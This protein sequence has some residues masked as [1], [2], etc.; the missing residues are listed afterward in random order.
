MSIKS[1]DKIQII[2][3]RVHNLKNINVSILRNKLT[4][5]T[6][7]SGSGKSSLAFDT[8]YAEG[9][10]RYIESLSSY[11][12][13]FLGRIEKPDIDDIKGISPAIAIEQKVNSS[14]PR[15]TVGTTTEIHDYLKLLFA[16]I[17]KTISPLSNKQVTKDHPEDVLKWMLSITKKTKMLITCPIEPPKGRTL[18][19]HIQVYIQ[20]GYN[21]V[22][23]NNEI[24]ELEIKNTKLPFQLIIDRV[25]NENSNENQSR[26]LDSLELA[27]HEGKGN[28]EI[29]SF[30]DSQPNTNYF[31]NLFKKDDIVFEQPS[32]DFFSFNNPYGA[33]K[34]CEGFGKVMGIDPSLVIPNPNLSVYQDAIV[35]WK[36]EKMSVWKEELINNAHYFDFPIHEPFKDLS[37]KDQSTLWKGNDYFKGIDYFFK[38]LEKKSYKIQYRVLLSRYRGRTTCDDCNGNRLRA[39]ANYV[40]VNGVSI[41]EVNKMSIENAI[42]YFENI[43]LD[44]NDKLVAK[45]LIDEISSRLGYLCDVGLGYLTLNRPSNTLSGGESQRINLAT[46]IGSSLVGS[47]Y[48][49]DEPSIGLHS[50]DSQQ[51]IKV[52]KKLRDI[53]NSVIVVEH[54]EEMMRAADEIIDIG[55]YAGRHGGEVVFQGN[56]NKLINNKNSLTAKYLIGKM[57]I[58]VP[59]FRRKPKDFILIEEAFLHNLKNISVKI[60]LSQICVVTGVSGSGKSTLISNILHQYFERYFINGL[61]KPMHCSDIKVDFNLIDGVEFIDQNPIGKSSRSNPI[62][63]IKGYDDIRQ[64]FS[65]QKHAK[66]NG[67]KP[68]HFSFN[69]DGGRCEKCQGEGQLTITMQFMADVHLKCDECDGQRFKDEVLEVKF[70]NKNISEILDMTVEES[71]T[72]FDHED[73][74]CQKIKGKISALKEVG[75]EYVQL[76]QSSSTLSGGEA[77]RIKLAS[78]LTQNRTKNRKLFI[79]DEPTTGLHFHDVKKLIKALQDLIEMGHHIIII[80]HHLDIIKIADWIID[81]GLEG[82]DNGGD[83]IFQGNPEDFLKSNVISYTKNHLK[84]HIE[85]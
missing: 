41:S 77:Q 56:H 64:L 66:V 29:V 38:Y 9:H 16:R 57:K 62:T 1:K 44:Q 61:H 32:L 6:G 24:K 18:E 53:G 50:R 59:K 70:K 21:K 4:V 33:C 78:F 79:F 52:L 34:K 69:V 58:D 54:D 63:Y 81:L 39:D 30:I 36:G 37:E 11:A 51:L 15:S 72:F 20:Q 84:N 48:I 49:L 67:F 55:P 80:E 27:F 35:C 74:I 71:L 65:R 46:S 45:R 12:R 42:R 68:G 85:N 13:L 31:N 14:N 73:S 7:V 60:P 76:G 47:M 3:A 5:I 25:T 19:D 8:L 23:V 28:C 26:I 82:G 43:E 40:K 83:L 75:L 17:G 10:R 22:W 2:G